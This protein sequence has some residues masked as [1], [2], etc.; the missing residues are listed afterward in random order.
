M[1]ADLTIFTPTYNRANLLRRCYESL[2]RQT[3]KDFVWQIIDDGSVDNTKD[4]VKYFI[5]EDKIKI[6]YEY[7][8]NRGKV[9]A[10]NRSMEITSSKYWLCLDS[11][12]YLFP[13]A[14]NIIYEKMKYIE[15]NKNICG[16]ISL[17]CNSE[18]KPM[19]GK[20]LPINIEFATQ[21]EIRY[22]YG[23]DPEYA[24]VYKTE[25]IK[26]YV[27]PLASNEKYMPL[28]YVPDQLDQKYKLLLVRDA[29]MACE[30]QPGGITD[31]QKKLAANNPE[32]VK[33]FTLQ[34]MQYNG[35][36]VY[37]IK[38]IITYDVMCIITRDRNFLNK[39]SSPW[40]SFILF[41]F[42]ILDYIIRYRRFIK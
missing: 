16:I 39:S 27:Y 11:D 37:R 32:S 8:T 10:I 12:D 29:I 30:Y 35:E 38:N 1:K 19:Q 33:K 13:E 15:N 28:S 7:K 36:F 22:K 6:Y 17:R 21:Y 2:L 34:R 25:I 18:K 40:L 9:S 3:C 20:T 4:I 14:V 5:A 24:Q 23:I 31:T 41:P 26:K 42:A